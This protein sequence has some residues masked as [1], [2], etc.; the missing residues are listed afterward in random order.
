[1]YVCI[2]SS[3]RRP[4]HTSYNDETTSASNYRRSG[5]YPRVSE[6]VSEQV[7]GRG[8]GGVG[9]GPKREKK[10]CASVPGAFF[11]RGFLNVCYATQDTKRLKSKKIDCVFVVFW[12]LEASES[13]PGA[14][15]EGL[16]RGSG[17]GPGGVREGS[18]KCFK[19][20]RS[21]LMSESGPR[22]QKKNV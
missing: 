11:A 12:S 10:P 6:E 21:R 3:A 1:M 18:E 16:G 19:R 9:R 20:L 15:R 22:I 8:L 7:S 13:R 5:K 17:R 4:N 14:A 2:D